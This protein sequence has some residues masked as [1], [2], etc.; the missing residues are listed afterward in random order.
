MGR[1]YKIYRLLLLTLLCVVITGCSTSNNPGPSLTPT[2]DPTTTEG[3][4]DHTS[5]VLVPTADGTI[6]YE[7]EVATIDASNISEG[8]VMVNY[9]GTNSKVKLQITGPD[10]ITYTYDKHGGYEA[11]PLPS[12]DGIYTIGVYENTDLEKNLYALAI[13]QD[14]DVTITNEFGPFLYPSQYVDFTSATLTVAKGAQLATPA[15][16]DLEVVENVYNYL[17]ENV[18][19]DYDKAKNVETGYLPNVDEILNSGTGI[20]FDYAALAA[21]MLRSQRIPTR[22]EIG[23]VGSEYHAWISVY[24]PEAGGWINGIIQFDG[25]KWNL[26]DPTFAASSKKPKQFTSDNETY[27]LKYVY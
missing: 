12:G 20:C 14:I 6:V 9:S 8:Y 26:L 19:Y 7:C 18:T 11:F 27:L 4:R 2:P 24:V 22:L 25:K 3:T 17:I 23:Y 1:F 16:N 13:S 15:N 21:T 10:Q 5:V